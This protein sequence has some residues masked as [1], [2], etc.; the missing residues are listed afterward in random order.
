MIKNILIAAIFAAFIF[1]AQSFS[2]QLN[3]LKLSDT[4]D[5]QGYAEL[6]KRSYNLLGF[7]DTTKKK[8]IRSKSI[9]ALFIGVGGGIT[10]P[11]AKFKENSDVTFGILGRLEFSSTG[12]FPFVI[13]AQVDYFSYPGADEF[14]TVNLLA[15]YRTKILG[16]GLNI[17]YSLAKLFRSSFTMP[18]LTVDVKSNR[19][20]REYDEARTLDGLP[21]EEQKISV[22]AGVGMTVFIFD[23]LV[24]YNYMKDNNFV[25]VYTK[26]KIPVVRF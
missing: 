7:Q 12:I 25:G 24:K 8:L 22:G 2:Q 20:K 10:V 9:S 11:L 18:F 17:E 15:N 4:K 21:R 16:I 19:I 5:I 14:K 1:T 6:N 26:T 23:F 13:G 3:D